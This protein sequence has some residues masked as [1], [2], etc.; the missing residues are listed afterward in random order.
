MLVVGSAN[1]SNTA[2]LV[3]VAEREGCRAELIEDAS[4]LELGWLAGVSSIGLTAGASA[5]DVLVQEVLDTL[6]SLGPLRLSEEK[7][8]EE[9]VRFSLPT[10][11]R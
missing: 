3:E 7:T 2:R 4:Q 1:S 10:Q 11:V 8:T 9:T 5:P 6:R